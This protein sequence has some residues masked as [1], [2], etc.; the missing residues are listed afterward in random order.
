MRILPSQHT[1][2][3]FQGSVE[4][5]LESWADEKSATPTQIWEALF[6]LFATHFKLPPE[7]VRQLLDSKLGRWMFDDMT[8]ALPKHSEGKKTNFTVAHFVNAAKPVF[9]RKWFVKQMRLEIDALESIDDGSE[10]APLQEDTGDKAFYGNIGDFVRRESGKTGFMSTATSAGVEA[11]IEGVFSSPAFMDFYRKAV[12]KAIRADKTLMASIQRDGFKLT[13]GYDMDDITQAVFATTEDGEL[14]FH[15]ELIVE[16]DDGQD[17]TLDEADL[18]E[19][20]VIEAFETAIA[21]AVSTEPNMHIVAL[22]EIDEALA[23]GDYETALQLGSELLARCEIDEAVIAEFKKGF[24]T[25]ATQRAR[26]GRVRAKA[27]TGTQLMARRARRRAARKGS[28]RM[29]RARYYKQNKRRISRRRAQLQ[30]SFDLDANTVVEMV[31]QG[32]TFVVLQDG[33]EPVFASSREIAEG[34]A[35]DAG[36]VVELTVEQIDEAKKKSKKCRSKGDYDDATDSYPGGPNGPAGDDE[37]DEAKGKKDEEDEEEPE[38]EEDEEEPEDEE[39]DETDESL[40]ES[41]ASKLANEIAKFL[42][43]HPSVGYGELATRFRIGRDVAQQAVIIA[44]NVAK[45]KGDEASWLY[46]A[47]EIMGTLMLR[48]GKGAGSDDAP[49]LPAGASLPRRSLRVG[50]AASVQG[51]GANLVEDSQEGAIDEAGR[52]DGSF[53]RKKFGDW[54]VRMV[55]GTL[56]LDDE[57][58]KVSYA[59]AQA[60]GEFVATREGTAVGRK[61]GDLNLPRALLDFLD[62]FVAES[63]PQGVKPTVRITAGNKAGVTK[64]AKQALPKATLKGKEGAIKSAHGRGESEEDTTDGDDLGEDGA[65]QP[66]L[67]EVS[68][69]ID[70]TEALVAAAAQN[71][72]DS[73]TK[74]RVQTKEGRVSMFVPAAVA[75]SIRKA[76]A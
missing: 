38:D 76:I 15:G 19:D 17:V 51:D 6:K 37:V 50:Q 56:W 69:S 29:K 31:E 39:D 30:N 75:D 16:G 46:L 45:K 25:S 1:G 35:G 3:G 33:E 70:K 44:S 57:K 27:K 72:L 43:K 73:T 71:G 42:K 52:F 21:E 40:A 74:V 14:P 62:G 9:T 61:L 5:F 36:A 23:E 47:K 55:R 11:K 53:P 34:I 65:T 4:S 60:D 66:G 67:V 20:V 58:R 18:M 41:E 32:M 59:L 12:V 64:V 2:F 28:A 48:A 63:V 22:R 8:H 54:S 68:T 7:H 49:S 24:K 26:M 10:D 13:E